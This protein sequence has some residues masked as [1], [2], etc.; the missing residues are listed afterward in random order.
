[1]RQPELPEIGRIVEITQGRDRG[2]FAIVIG[3]T[4]DRFVFLADGRLRKVDKPKKKNVL[5]I[6]KTPFMAEEVATL[7]K[8]GGKVTNAH[9]RHALRVALPE[10]LT[11]DGDQEGGVT[12]GQ[13]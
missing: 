5:H 8:S 4:G 12:D 10:L 11:M 6:R 3:H 2:H 7:V 9:L 1:L 13:R